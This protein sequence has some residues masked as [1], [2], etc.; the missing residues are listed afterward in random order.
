MASVSER[1]LGP[2]QPHV[3]RNCLGKVGRAGHTLVPYLTV[4]VC[5]SSL[6]PAG[7]KHIIFLYV[8]VFFPLFCHFLFFLSFDPHHSISL[9]LLLFLSGRFPRH[10]W[11]TCGFIGQLSDDF[12]SILFN[13]LPVSVRK[14]SYLLQLSL[15]KCS[16]LL[17]CCLLS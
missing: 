4:W 11:P 17:P 10:Q 1:G 15:Q 13:C 6:T 16:K 2:G 8:S 5:L 3:H 14:M 12:R 9:F 7:N